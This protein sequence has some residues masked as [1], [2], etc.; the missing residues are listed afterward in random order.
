MFYA[1]ADCALTAETVLASSP[2]I[3]SQSID[4]SG[5]FS[6]ALRGESG[7]LYDV[8][9]SVCCV[10]RQRGVF[11]T[12]RAQVSGRVGEVQ[13]RDLRLEGE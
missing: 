8:S 6:I 7:S 10:H 5:D 1:S 3:V 11:Q 12:D 9:F 13:Q 2:E 4:G